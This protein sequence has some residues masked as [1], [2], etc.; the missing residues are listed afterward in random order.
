VPASTD[1]VAVLILRRDSICLAFAVIPGLILERQ[2]LR[3]GFAS[4]RS[5]SPMK[6]PECGNEESSKGV[7][8]CLKC[9]T[10]LDPAVMKITPE[11]VFPGLFDVHCWL[12]G[13]KRRKGFFGPTRCSF[14]ICFTV[15]SA[16]KQ[17]IA[18]NGNLR[19]AVGGLTNE[20]DLV[21]HLRVRKEDFAVRRFDLLTTSFNSL[22]YIYRHP[23]PVIPVP[24][25]GG[26]KLDLKLTA[27]SGEVHS[28][29]LTTFFQDREPGTGP[30]PP[31][32]WTSS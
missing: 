28:A 25:G 9:G 12:E 10:P 4:S 32:L 21:L 18:I 24:A 17:A 27:E 20:T 15:M 11:P 7:R 3:A 16:P 29:S 22:S 23:E 5:T 26:S 30:P 19:L 6:C 8:F 2:S 13:K 31:N 1:R 14:A